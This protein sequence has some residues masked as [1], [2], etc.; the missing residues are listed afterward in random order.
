MNT[1]FVN[2]QAQE[3]ISALDRG[4]LYGDSLFETIAVI[5]GKGLALDS[6]LQ[7][8]EKGI[9][10]LSFNTEVSTLT[11]EINHLLEPLK[12]TPVSLQNN[13]SKHV[14]RITLTRSS[15]SRGYKPN[16]EAQATRILS[17][18]EWPHYSQELYS[19]GMNVGISKIQYAQ[20]PF[21]AGIKHGNRLEQVIASQSI[22]NEI[23]DVL[24]LDTQGR[25][26]STS[27]G[28]IF[29]KFNDTWFTPDLSLCGIEGIVRTKL[30][31]HFSN[32]GVTCQVANMTLSELNSRK[33]DINAAFSCN[34]IMGIMPIRSLHNLSDQPLDSI[35][36]SNELRNTL[37]Q[38]KIIAL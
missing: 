15:Q 12:E 2:G 9:D 8:L 23:D 36:A 4:L 28:N 14:L 18:H 26:I 25:V 29:I 10:R 1:I 20:Q 24:M 38:S 21:L 34:S 6:H 7:R 22:S 3:T 13:S 27:K 11:Y 19:N 30:I 32:T 35:Q 16:P 31:E 5:D 17:L 33:N 37:R